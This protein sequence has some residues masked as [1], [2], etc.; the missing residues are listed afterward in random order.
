MI[1]KTAVIMFG[2]MLIL[3]GIVGI[4]V[5]IIQGVLLILA[6][7]F[8]IHEYIPIK[9]VQDIKDYIYHKHKN[10]KR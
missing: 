10:H 5:P 6:G 4:F 7:L 2:A 8:L 3:I 1:K 9:F